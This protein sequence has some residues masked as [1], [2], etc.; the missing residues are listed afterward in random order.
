MAKFILYLIESG[1]CLALMYL[2]YFLFLKKETYFNFNR[3]YLLGIMIIALVIPLLHVTIAVS[4][5]ENIEEPFNDV[6]KLRSYYSDFVA[7]YSEDDFEDRYKNYEAMVFEE[8]GYSTAVYYNSINE[9]IEDSAVKMES[10]QEPSLFHKINFVKVFIAIY[11]IGVFIFFVRLIILLIWLAKAVKQNPA[12]KHKNYKLVLMKKE[13]PPFSFFG[14]IFVTKQATQLDEYEQVLAHEQVHVG[15]MHS[16]DLI[17]AHVITVF[18]WFN[19]LV[20][21][22]QK[23]IKTTHEYIADSKVVNQGFELFDYQSLLLSQLVSIQSVE[24]VNNFNLISIKKRIEMMTKNKSRFS[25]KLK[26]LIIIPMVLIAF[27][28]F[29]HMTVKSPVLNF[30]N[31][32]TT[33]TSNLDGIWE[34][35]DSED[36]GILIK[37]HDNVLSVLESAQE[38]IVAE[39]LITIKDKEIVINSF[40]SKEALKYE[41]NNKQLKIWWNDSKASIYN[42]TSYANSFEA[43]THSK[44]KDIILPIASET[45]I[46]EKS[47]YVYSIYVHENKYYVADVECTIANLESTLKQRVAKFNKLDKPF[48][49]ARLVVDKNTTMKPVY[50]LH[51]VMRK[52][53]LYKVAYATFP[54]EYASA[55]QYHATGIAQMLPPTVADGAEEVDEDEVKDIL[56]VIEPTRDVNALSIKFESFVQNHPKYLA[57]FN[58]NNSTTYNEYIAILDM[59]RRVIYK[60]RDA[61]SVQKYSMKYSDLPKTMQK[62]ARKKYPLS[63]SMNNTDED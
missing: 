54:S 21:L 5:F 59:T 24:L 38:V 28:L 55:L 16:L 19:P 47:Q 39:L 45:K 25:A 53:R 32:N 7:M 34:N 10:L 29:A 14:Y 63:I 11:L 1:L 15:Q 36:F 50:N 42:K 43:F 8:E 4:S 31:F 26:A 6:G 61:Y 52:L 18:M 48:I 35:Q 23:A 57:A 58:W 27:F 17:I 22:L 12:E 40:R 41:L 60:L 51:Q 20:W 62:E 37:F 13:V 9:T 33:K 46:L 2:V 30:T 56:I 3:I 49:T 44:H